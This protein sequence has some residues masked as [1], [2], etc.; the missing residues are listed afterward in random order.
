MEEKEQVVCESCEALINVGVAR[1]DNDG[2]WLC[3][4]CYD[5][6]EEINVAE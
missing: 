2:L 5:S 3:Q 1:M 4:E 6:A